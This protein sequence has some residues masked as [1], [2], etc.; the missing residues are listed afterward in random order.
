ML[1]QVVSRALSTLTSVRPYPSGVRPATI[2][3]S[4]RVQATPVTFIDGKAL[5]G[6]D[7]AERFNERLMKTM[8]AAS[9]VRRYLQ[10][11][12]E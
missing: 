12:Y 3:R 10:E 8:R 7:P 6:F 4:S 11:D 9:E 1:F 2:T 5:A